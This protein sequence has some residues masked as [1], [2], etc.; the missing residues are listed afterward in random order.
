MLLNERARNCERIWQEYDLWPSFLEDFV[1]KELVGL[2]PSDY[3]LREMFS[4]RAIAAL[5]ASCVQLINANRRGVRM[6]SVGSHG[7]D[8][9]RPVE[10][11]LKFEALL[12]DWAKSGWISV[13]ENPETGEI[14]ANVPM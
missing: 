14:S 4:A 13:N 6:V 11:G 5:V 3:N 10:D 2:S 9:P 1:Y 7:G 8:E 12:K